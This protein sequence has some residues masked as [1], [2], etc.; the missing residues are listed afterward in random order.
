MIERPKRYWDAVVA[1][2]YVDG[3]SNAID[4]YKQAFGAVELFRIAD[5]N[6]KILH[7]EI[8]IYGSLVMIGDADNKLYGEPRSL[9]RTTAS[10]HIREPPYY[11]GR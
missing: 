8:S 6:G 11:G 7:A 3:A 5:P 10:L 4:F 1:H 2:I 9:G